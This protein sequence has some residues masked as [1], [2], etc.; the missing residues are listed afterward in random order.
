MAIK[1]PIAL[2]WNSLIQIFVCKAHWNVVSSF[3]CHNAVSFL[4]LSF[5]RKTVHAMTPITVCLKVEKGQIVHCRCF[6]LLILLKFYLI[7]L[8]SLEK[9]NDI[10][11][12]WHQSTSSYFNCEKCLPFL[13]EKFVTSVVVH[14][15]RRGHCCFC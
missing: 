4:R 7:F 12:N 11:L 3:F 13:M 14:L 10:A 8:H 9:G 1:V 5:S 6:L 15:S 2:F